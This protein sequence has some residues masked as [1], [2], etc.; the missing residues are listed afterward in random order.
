M[1][2][3]VTRQLLA[4]ADVD[5]LAPLMLALRSGNTY[6]AD[7]PSI[8]NDLNRIA[9]CGNYLHGNGVGQGFS[10]PN[11]FVGSYQFLLERAGFYEAGWPT[12]AAVVRDTLDLACGTMSL[13]GAGSC[14]DHVIISFA[15]EQATG[16][17]G[18]LWFFRPDP[19]LSAG[20]QPGRLP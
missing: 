12:R 13:P 10:F 20:W 18:A 11:A 1:A 6:D 14:V 7:C 15:S 4:G 5:D 2:S 8:L 3:L 17:D 19:A 16:A 9:G